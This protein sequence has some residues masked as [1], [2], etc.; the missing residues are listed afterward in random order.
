[1]KWNALALAALALALASTF[2]FVA[3]RMEV[4]LLAIAHAFI[5]LAIW[6]FLRRHRTPPETKS[7]GDPT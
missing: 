6:L 2:P 1:M 7:K 3:D 5:A 4:A